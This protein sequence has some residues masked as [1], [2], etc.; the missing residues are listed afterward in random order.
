MEEISKKRFAKSK[1]E[2]SL[3]QNLWNNFGMPHSF[4][5]SVADILKNWQ[6]ADLEMVRE[7]R[8]V[9]P[10]GQIRF[11][12]DPETIKQLNITNPPNVKNQTNFEFCMK[13]Y[14]IW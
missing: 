12:R 10:D 8:D 7:Y 13:L 11:I 2:L 5:L 4:D 6:F 1:V 9:I 14:Y 3:A